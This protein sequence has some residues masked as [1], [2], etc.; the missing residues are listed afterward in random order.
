MVQELTPLQRAVLT[1]KTLRGRLDELERIRREPIAV[2]GMGCRFP[3]GADSPERYWA[4]LRDGVDVVGRVPADR[5]D[6]D[7][8]YE[9]EPGPGWTMN[10][11]EGGFLREP[12]A[13]FDPEFFGIAPRE[14][15]SLDPQQRL[16]LEVAW[17]ALE[18]GGIAPDSLVG[19]DTGVYI[20]FLNSDYGRIPFNAV[21]PLDLPYVGTGSGLDFPAGRIA[22]VLGLQGPCMVLGTACSSALTAIHVASQALRMGEASLALA[23]AVNL[24]LHPD[25]NIILSKMRALAPDG[26]CRAFDAGASGYGRGEGC[27]VVVLERLADALARG[28]RILGLVR[29]S[30]VNHDGPSGGLTVPNGPAQEKLLRRTLAVGGVTPAEVDYVEAHGTGTPLGDPIELRALDAVLGPGREQP[31]LV[32]S[33]KTNI[34]HLEAAAGMASLLKVL[35]AM[36]HERIPAHLHLQRPNPAVDWTRMRLEVPTTARPW[37]AGE[38][39]RI[40]GISGFGLS[41]INAHVLVEEPPRPPPRVADPAPRPTQLLTL[42]ARDRKALAE[43]ATRWSTALRSDELGQHAL[44]DITFTAN[45]G[46]ARLGQRLAVVADSHAGMAGQLERFV[47]GDPPGP[48]LAHGPAAA[49]APAAPPRLAFLFTGQGAQLLGMGEQ[50]YRSEPGFRAVL[51][52]CDAVLAPRLGASLHALLHP[53]ERDAAAQARLDRTG[54]AQPALFALELALA[55]TWM[56]WG[57]RPDRVLGHSVGEYAA[58][59]VAGV[60]SLEDGLLLISERARLMQSL[61]DGGAMAALSASLAQAQALLAGADPRLAI[62]AING[63]HATVLSGPTAALDELLLRAA[64]LGLRARRLQVSHAFHSP[65]MDPICARFAEVVAGIE[66]RPPTIP[67]ISNLDGREVGDEVTRPGYWVEHLRRPVA[68]ARGIT[69]LAAA[70]V[71]TFL[72]IGPQPTLV[73]LGRACVPEA[74]PAARGR[75]LAS[76]RPGRSDGEQMFETL[77]EL[78]TAGVEVD[79]RALDAGRDRRPVAA[80]TYPFQR[81]ALWLTLGDATWDRPGV[82]RTRGAAAGH[83]L[84]GSR[85]PSPAA[86]HEFA[87]RITARSPAY[88]ADHRVHGE[89]VMPGA[90][91]AELALAGATDLLGPVVTIE[92]LRFVEVLTL[93]RDHEL[94]TLVTPTATP[95]EAS[96][97][98]FSEREHGGWTLHARAHARAGIPALHSPAPLASLRAAC[99]REHAI[100]DH[101]AELAR[102]GLDYGPWFRAIRGLWS[103]PAQVLA[104]LALPDHAIAA[105]HHLHPALLD[106][107]FQV[108]G[109]AFDADAR[110]GE[111]AWLPVGLERLHL[112]RR[113][114]RAAWV[115]A[116]VH[117]TT[118]ARGGPLQRC[119]FDLFDEAGDLGARIEG[120]QLRRVA[121][122]SLLGRRDDPAGSWLYALEWQP[123][124]LPV[125]A[126]PPA[127]CLILPGPD[128]LGEQLAAT[129]RARGWSA[130]LA[131]PSRPDSLAEL[132]QADAPAHLV[133]LRGARTG[134]DALP[135]TALRLATQALELVQ[136]LVGRRPPD[137]LALW[138]VT[139][140]TQAAAPGDLLPGLVAAPLW[141]L[142]KAIARELP[143]L[144]CRRIDLDAARDARDAARLADELMAAGDEDELALRGDRRLVARLVRAAPLP[145][146]G[147]N[148][149]PAGSYLLTGGLGGLGLQSA[150]RLAARGARHLILVGRG[151][152][153]AAA[154]SRLAALAAAGV[155]VRLVRAD[156]ADAD[157]V[158]GLFAALADSSPPLRGIVHAAGIVDDGILT[159][160]SPGRFARVFAPKVDGAWN[161]HR[162]APPGL[163]FLIFFGSAAALLGS[164]GQS[165]YVAAN[166]FLDALAHRRTAHALPA[167]SLDWGGWSEH[168][169]A[170]GPQ[171]RQRMERL[172]VAAI[173]PDEGLAIFER[174]LGVRGQLGVF[175]VDWA[176][177]GERERRPLHAELVQRARTDTTASAGEGTLR[178]AIA[179]LPAEARRDALTRHVGTLVNHVLGRPADEPFDPGA[180]FF[181]QGMDSL[182][183]VELRNMLQRALG[184]SLPATIAFDSPTLT[185]LVDHLAREILRLTPAPTPDEPPAPANIDGDLAS[186]LA[187]LDELDDREIEARLRRGHR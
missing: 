113:G 94:R 104:A 176:R 143:E 122:D 87:A 53:P 36:Q 110:S 181:E 52:R 125:V 186:L 31:L 185:A 64:A 93:G 141:G 71:D 35:L 146:D 58:A 131:G 120:L 124:P 44:A 175:P 40:A 164:A 33:V 78:W 129:L 90:A 98:I 92:A 12:I 153:P 105:D 159:Q 80:P 73:A 19:S 155:A 83:P 23:G 9:P 38:R 137:R 162:L 161:L 121:R 34:A 149:D 72:E 166:A 103:G 10:V 148:L 117:A 165:S 79:L 179:A 145:V 136:T 95:G 167:A 106:A 180:G 158:A 168:G 88:L 39:P 21:S 169:A 32:G 13:A 171:F 138:L 25:N 47:A 174:S 170:S 133:D 2:V 70:G 50:L 74:S 101:Y 51:D 67:L 172:G 118:D 65:L 156:I 157:A 1:I 59:C 43:L 97:E 109:A 46:R 178:D 6:A 187:G 11:R 81:R 96:V 37:P 86:S 45:T 112:R 107:C 76:L 132:L 177:L 15:V 135:A 63:P 85:R 82:A 126:R 102:A 130:A 114:L 55:H 184:A 182:M 20:G 3:G 30:A 160:Q 69:S 29:G 48:S 173:A 66:L 140:G 147:P 56:A 14:A 163:D 57:V 115:H 152:P 22:Y 91:W 127:R 108:V 89:V 84:L 26:R 27:G 18:H 4:L 17:E 99:A 60:F 24:I 62:A 8:L 119:D 54:N 111:R 144:G 128:G 49:A 183:S 16:L 154:S 142:G 123:R 151:E 68:F 41:G 77:A 61:P 100:T 28:H 5:W 116:R 75:W 7:A 42:S 150:E 139:R 134:D